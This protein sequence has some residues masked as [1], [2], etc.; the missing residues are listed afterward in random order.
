MQV[1]ATKFTELGY[2]GRDVDDIVR[3]LADAAQALTRNRLSDA[4]LG[5]A[6]RWVEDV[7]LR[8]LLGP[9]T[10]LDTFRHARCSNSVE[11][12]LCKR[13]FVLRRRTTSN[14][15]CLHVMTAAAAAAAAHF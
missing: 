10:P 15:G 13:C 12:S 4:L 5:L 7:L 9:D 2:V 6:G 8:E 11:T 3:D 14:Q 1:E